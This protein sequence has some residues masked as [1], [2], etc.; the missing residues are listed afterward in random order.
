MLRV[1]VADDTIIFRKII[2]DALAEIPGVEM[3]GTA[4]NGKIALARL[5]AL[6]PDILTLDIEMPELDGL[7]VLEAIRREG[8]DV[9]A[10]MLSSYTQRGGQMTMKALELGAF[11]FIPKPE[12]R[13]LEENK[14]LIRA[15][16]APMLAAY[17]RRKELRSTLRGRRPVQA[18]APLVQPPPT[19][20]QSSAAVPLAPVRILGSEVIAIGI[21]T[22][23]PNALARIIPQ[24]PADLAVPVLIVQH[25]PPMFTQ[26][27]AD[28]L[29]QKSPLKIKE[30]ESGET[31]RPGFVYIAPGG[32][33][34]KILPGMEPN[35]RIV[36]ITDDPPENNCRP[37]ADYLFRSIAHHYREKATG[38][39]MTGM[40]NDGA[41]GLRLMK[42][43]GAVII[44]QDE[45]SCVVYG[46]PKA[47][48]DAG[49]VDIQVPLDQIV[50]EVL[51]TVKR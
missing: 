43:A 26:S 50:G 16:L 39:I 7:E 30:A 31:I 14:E 6:K 5:R 1:L 45:A 47:A 4:S 33:Q 41:L 29:D 20:V 15:S 28:N 32:K 8:I 21:S 42:R 27:L 24:L 23:G 2:S 12:G 25:M 37:S 46:M 9:G 48:M 44:G 49:V 17:A 19:R 36:K 18:A 38:V 13:G 40:G 11:D 22:G 3:V 35:S 10:I 34:M 51:R